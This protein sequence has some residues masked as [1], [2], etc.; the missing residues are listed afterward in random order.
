MKYCVKI[1]EYMER[2]IEVDADSAKEAE[3]MVRERYNKEEIV[4]DFTDWVYTDYDVN[5][6]KEV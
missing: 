1:K 3:N 4:L 5:E 2:E 6:L